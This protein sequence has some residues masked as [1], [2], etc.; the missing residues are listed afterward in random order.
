M[1]KWGNGKYH[2]RSTLFFSSNSKNKKNG[3]I[4]LEPKMEKNER[5]G[6][7]IGDQSVFASFF[8]IKNGEM[9]EWVKNEEK[10]TLLWLEMVLVL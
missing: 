4:P 2:W 9:R 3:R 1:K 8:S 7:T 6:E 5:M 10:K